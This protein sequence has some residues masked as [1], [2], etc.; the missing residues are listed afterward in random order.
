MVK[1]RIPVACS[2][3]ARFRTRGTKKT[4]EPVGHESVISPAWEGSAVV[5]APSTTRSPLPRPSPVADPFHPPRAQEDPFLPHH[6]DRLPQASRRCPP[7]VPRLVRPGEEAVQPRRSRYQGVAG[8]G[9]PAFRH[10]Q[11]PPEEVSHHGLK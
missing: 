7:R 1:V 2:A 9:C 4:L 8:Q 10:R 5:L 6:R 3:R 11:E